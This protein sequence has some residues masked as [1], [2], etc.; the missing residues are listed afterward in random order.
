[1]RNIKLTIQYDGTRYSGWQSQVNSLAVQDVIER[2]IACV[3][4]EK[5][6]LIAASRTDSGV[7][8]KGQV[9]NF[10]TASRI[11]LE[12]LKAALNRVLPSDIAI[13][14]ANRVP[15]DF[16]SRYA[17]TGKLYRYSV[18]T[19]DPVP[20]FCRNFVTPVRHKLDIDVMRAESRVILGRKDFASFQGARSKRADSV[21]ELRSFTIQ[22]RGSFI[23][24][25][26]EA[27]GFLYNMA[28]SIAGTFIDIGRGHLETGCLETILKKQDRNLAGSTAPAR[29]LCLM[30]VRY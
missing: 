7:H 6:R 30:K 2:A 12:S 9:A 5:I 19:S 27:D 16:H 4:G 10:N 28:R 18:Y 20:P 22:K 24:F 23:Y 3:T 11:A 1:M 14:K 26:M 15:M 25:D 29:G 21:R 8:A 17:S 13:I